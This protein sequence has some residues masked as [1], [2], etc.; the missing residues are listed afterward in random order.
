M[1]FGSGK[2]LLQSV[3]WLDEK[4]II[5]KSSKGKWGGKQRRECRL[6]FSKFDMEY[7]G[8]KIDFCSC[9]R[10]VSIVRYFILVL[11][12]TLF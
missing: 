12:I 7:T 6:F 2:D 10:Y 8:S 1:V 5:V 3:D 4:M 11:D 9:V